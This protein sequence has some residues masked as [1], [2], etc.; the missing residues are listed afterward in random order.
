MKVMIGGKM[1]IFIIIIVLFLSSI[2][3]GREINKHYKRKRELEE[4]NDMYIS[5]I[6]ILSN[7][8]IICAIIALS[9]IAI[10][11]VKYLNLI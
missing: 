5:S 2:I 3:T 7:R 9:T 10:I 4:T 11:V 6:L 1:D 8:G